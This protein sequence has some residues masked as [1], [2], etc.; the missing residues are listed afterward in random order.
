[1]QVS[2]EKSVPA[3]DTASAEA[4]RQELSW[5]GQEQ[6]AGWCDCW[7]GSSRKHDQ[8][9]NG[10][11]GVRSPRTVKM[12]RHWRVWSCFSLTSYREYLNHIY[13]EQYNESPCTN[14]SASTA[15]TL[16]G[17]WAEE[18]QDLAWADWSRI[19]QE[20]GRWGSGAGTGNTVGRQ[21]TAAFN[22]G[23]AVAVGRS[24]QSWDIFWRAD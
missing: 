9:G 20:K 12:E 4:L 18:W 13:L 21:I 2:R 8:G 16:G 6:Q 15:F 17:L 7:A 1:M 3:E 24:G 19:T 11:G 23:A 14:H 5:P 10:S 22:Q